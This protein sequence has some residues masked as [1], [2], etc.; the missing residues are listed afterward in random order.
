[1]AFSL[2]KNSAGG[3]FSCSVALEFLDQLA[4]FKLWQNLTASAPC[5]IADA[6][7]VAV[8]SELDGIFHMKRRMKNATEGFLCWKKCFHFIPDWLW[9]SLVKHC[10][11][12]MQLPSPLARIR[13]LSCSYQA[14]VAD[15]C[16]LSE[17]THI[18][19]LSDRMSHRCELIITAVYVTACLKLNVLRPFRALRL[20]RCM[21]NWFNRQQMHH[22]NDEQPPAADTAHYTVLISDVPPCQF[23]W[24]FFFLMCKLSKCLSQMK[25]NESEG[26]QLRDSGLLFMF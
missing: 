5:N 8:S 24:V 25:A 1:M 6:A 22:M 13:R 3:V 16:F 20:S 11:A 21:S 26:G 12:S 2:K 19:L 4:S 23:V 7:V 14:V 17:N 15:L 10:D 9:Q 18:D